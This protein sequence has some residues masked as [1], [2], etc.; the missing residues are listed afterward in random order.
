VLDGFEL[1]VVF[2]AIG[3]LDDVVEGIRDLNKPG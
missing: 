1:L 2:D 3:E